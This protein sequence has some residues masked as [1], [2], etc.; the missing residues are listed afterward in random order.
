[1]FFTT[2]FSS[3]QHKLCG[4][5]EQLRAQ[6]L[7]KAFKMQQQKKCGISLTD[8]RKLLMKETHSWKKETPHGKPR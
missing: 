5:F 7:Q 4:L 2:Y 3:E 1:M 8:G 6:T